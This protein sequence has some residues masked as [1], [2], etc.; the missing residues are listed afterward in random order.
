M[1]RFALISTAAVVL[2]WA[3]SLQAQ[4]YTVYDPVYPTYYAAPTTVYYRSAPTTT[5]YAPAPTTVFY[6][7][8]PTTTYYA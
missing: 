8:A 4:Y 1:N 7:S 6:V 2:L 3:G 5:Y